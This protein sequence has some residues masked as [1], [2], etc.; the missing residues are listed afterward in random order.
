MTLTMFSLCAFADNRELLQAKF[1]KPH[2]P[3]ERVIELAKKYL[4]QEKQVDLK[5]YKLGRVDFTYYSPVDRPNSIDAI[6]W[7][8]G[9]ECKQEAVPGCDLLL[10]ISNDT[11][12]KFTLYP[13]L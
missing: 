9:F 7:T 2:L 13:G 8:V 10:G 1:T 11:K 12:P 5:N 4:H 6:G 3:P